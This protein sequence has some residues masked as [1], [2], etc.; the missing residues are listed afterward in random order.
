MMALLLASLLAVRT[1]RAMAR[2]LAT[3]LGELSVKSELR[4]DAEVKSD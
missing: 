4:T 2:S 3:G 1:A